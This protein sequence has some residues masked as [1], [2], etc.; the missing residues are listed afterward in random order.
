[1]NETHDKADTEARQKIEKLQE[2]NEELKDAMLIYTG[3]A[4]QMN[5]VH[6]RNRQLESLLV[7]AADAL[8]SGSSET[9][10]QL[11]QELRKAAQ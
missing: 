8:E 2:E 10:F 6:V 5:K 9:H 4:G 7:R 1:M 11:I 3:L